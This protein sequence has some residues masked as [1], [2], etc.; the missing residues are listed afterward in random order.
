MI[1]IARILTEAAATQGQKAIS[2]ISKDLSW[3]WRTA[4]NC[5]VQGCYE[6]DS[7]SEQIT[8]LFNIARE[9]KIL[10]YFIG[11]PNSDMNLSYWKF[12]ALRR[13][14]VRM[15]NHGSTLRKPLLL[16]CPV[17]VSNLPRCVM[18]FLPLY[19]V[20]SARSS[21]TA[22]NSIDVSHLAVKNGNYSKHHAGR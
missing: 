18:T 15:P 8:E 22:A 3:L 9:V 11:N 7:T 5:A 4:Y 6:W 14:S 21:M 1:H 19:L 2:L 17:K 16:L 13:L 20:F 10:Y 12:P